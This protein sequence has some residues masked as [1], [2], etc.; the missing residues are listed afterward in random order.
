MK[1][2]ISEADR[3]SARSIVIKNTARFLNIQDWETK[4][5]EDL[6]TEIK[7]SDKESDIEVCKL[8][9]KYFEAYDNW[10]GFYQNCIKE[11]N[12]SGRE[13]ILN[14]QD[15][16]NLN[17]LITQRRESL[18]VLETKFKELQQIEINSNKFKR[19]TIQSG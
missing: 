16:L 19:E 10:F 17:K 1:I 8:I 15:K 3:H 4:L 14:P 2:Y 9:N 12:K 7:S 6:F 5:V 18:E 11:E 13:Y